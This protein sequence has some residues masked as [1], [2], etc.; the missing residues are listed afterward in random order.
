MLCCWSWYGCSC[1]VVICKL[2]LELWPA[3]WL[4][5]GWWFGLLPKNS[6]RVYLYLAGLTG[7]S[8]AFEIVR[9]LEAQL[10]IL[11]SKRMFLELPNQVVPKHLIR[12][13]STG[14]H[15]I[16]KRTTLP[17]RGQP[18]V[19]TSKTRGSTPKHC[20]EV[21][22]VYSLREYSVTRWPCQT[23]SSRFK[24]HARVHT[25]CYVDL[26]CFYSASTNSLTV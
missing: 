22:A 5:K 2:I 16:S 14:D 24:V 9:W 20:T 13:Q 26:Y 1:L 4:G 23:N 21:W 10:I 19:L 12:L 6:G 3:G 7:T 11:K 17:V 18:T 15:T 8:P 25:T